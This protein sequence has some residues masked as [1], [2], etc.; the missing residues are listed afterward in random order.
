MSLDR[1]FVE[2][3]RLAR[4]RLRAT[5]SRLSDA[6]L[7]QNVGDGWTIAA[8]L[9]HVAFW[10]R[11][12][13]VLLEKWQKTGEV[14]LPS[15]AD[16]D[17]INDAAQHLIG[18]IPPRAAATEAVAAADAVDSALETLNAELLDRV[19]ANSAT[20]VD[21]A[22]HRVEHLDEIDRLLNKE[23]SSR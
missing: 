12:A 23:G 1:S 20:R 6:D 15:P 22:R 7:N 17:V 5:V 19:I 14:P 11:R 3:N 8:A 10:D 4:E 16:I 2:V 9:A 18:L 21:R 13:Q